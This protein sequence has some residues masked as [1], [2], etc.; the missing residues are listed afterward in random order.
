MF[1]NEGLCFRLPL[2]LISVASERSYR[3]V[4]L[5][6]EETAVFL[7][8]VADDREAYS[9]ASVKVELDGIS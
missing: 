8:L 4:S 1:V 9:P 7:V 6:C 5:D 2:D 3:Q